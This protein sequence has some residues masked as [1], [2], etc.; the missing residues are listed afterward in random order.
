MHERLIPNILVVLGLLAG[1]CLEPE[2]G[3]SDED[4]IG[5]TTTTGFPE[6]GM[7][8]VTGSAEM[9]TGFLV[10]PTI[11]ITAAHCIATPNSAYGFY[12][13]LG[14]LTTV[15]DVTQ[16]TLDTLPNVEKHAV[17]DSHAYPL[18]NINASPMRYD[19]AYVRLAQPI[20]GVTPLAFGPNPALHASCTAVGY[21]MIS[22]TSPTGLVK[23]TAN[24]TVSG[25]TA[26]DI[27]VGYGT[28]TPHKGDSGGPLIC[29]GTVAGVFSWIDN[30]TSSTATRRYAR[31]D[32]AVGVWIDSIVN[33]PVPG[34]YQSGDT[35]DY[36]LVLKQSQ[37]VA[38]MITQ[39]HYT[40]STAPRAIAVNEDGLG[41]VTVQPGATATDVERTALQACYI[42]GGR[43]PCALL[44][45]D[46]EF[47][48]DGSALNSSF[49]AT[50]A[51]PTVL[52]A[53]PF[54]PDRIRTGALVTYTAKTGFKAVA[55]GLDGTAAFV[56]TATDSIG[57][58]AE[59]DRLAMERCEMAAT[60]SPCTMFAR[61]NTVVLDPLAMNWSPVIDYT[62]T[63]V[64]PNIPGM[65]VA[66]YNAHMVPYLA[67]L[68]QGYQ[69]VT[70]IA[71]DGSGGNS[72]RT[73]STQANS[74]ALAFCN[75]FVV[76][77]AKC[78]R[79]ATNHNVSFTP[80]T[81]DAVHNHSLA[82]HCNAM[83]RLDCATHARMGCHTSGTYY[84]TH[85]GGVALETCTF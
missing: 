30:L 33:P 69:G 84:T 32:G 24:V 56:P 29:N 8:G 65:T 57:T 14:K 4:I 58:Q 42:I 80:S 47:A 45:L 81:L 7:V 41:Y 25:T 50:L 83:P 6:V 62:R 23:K 61:G 67:G 64:A 12:T 77:P 71:E 35:F 70:Y 34:E 51:K 9:C 2:Q 55:V 10:S 13:G 37:M 46:N 21:G 85:A 26:Y 60:N 3:S 78:F 36:S 40:T 31:I 59:A 19:V 20:T 68:A 16:H 76:A 5:G 54:V 74:E 53:I 49:T 22:T 73:T 43:K 63:T 18:A 52:T 75:Q 15:Q 27:N 1:G 28:G 38:T 44:A 72:W 11:V 39:L 17:L 79:Y 48:L 82:L 66:N